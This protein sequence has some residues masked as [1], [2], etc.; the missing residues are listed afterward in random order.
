M[1]I[2]IY[3]DNFI[4]LIIVLFVITFLLLSGCNSKISSD[5]S[6]SINAEEQTG[7]ASLQTA[8]NTL[9]ADDGMRMGRQPPYT[10]HNIIGRDLNSDGSASL[11]ILSI[12]SAKP[13]NF[14]YTSP[15][16]FHTMVWEESEIDHPIDFDKVL[17]PDDLFI[18]NAL[19]IDEITD[20][21]SS[22]VDELELR[23]GLY[24]IRSLNAGDIWEHTFDATT[25]K[26]LS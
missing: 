22:P 20:K 13:F 16:E 7:R 10:I 23:N 9:N 15:E 25:G 8:I 14:I 18:K 12:N 4:G 5:N 2:K 3:E 6:I 17:S 21:G 24:Y 1:K 26:Q 11:W 19:L